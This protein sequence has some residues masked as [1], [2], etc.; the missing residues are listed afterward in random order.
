EHRVVLHEPAL[1]ERG[2]QRVDRLLRAVAAVAV[3]EEGGEDVLGPH[4]AFQDRLAQRGAPA[5]HLELPAARTARVLVDADDRR[6]AGVAD[7][8]GGAVAGELLRHLPGARVRLVRALL[9]TRGT[10]R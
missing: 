1:V 3:V 6:R 9:R 4:P 10:V 5:G 7:L 8:D 2:P